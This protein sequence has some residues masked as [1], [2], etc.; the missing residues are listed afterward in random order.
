MESK[1][2]YATTPALIGERHVSWFPTMKSSCPRRSI[3]H[4]ELHLPTDL[5]IFE[6]QPHTPFSTRFKLG[7]KYRNDIRM[8]SFAPVKRFQGA[9]H[10]LS[11]TSCPFGPNAIGTMP[12]LSCH[13]ASPSLPKIVDHQT[14]CSSWKKTLCPPCGIAS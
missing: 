7:I 12:G 6:Q 14:P 5:A 3:R 4:R 1:S 9:I 13:G 11:I 10:R 2:G 8:V